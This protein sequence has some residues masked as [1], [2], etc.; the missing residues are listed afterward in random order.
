MLMNGK[1]TTVISRPC[2]TTFIY[3]LREPYEYFFQF[4][5]AEL[6][7]HIVFQS[8]VYSRQKD[9]A[10][11]FH[12]SEEEIL[13]FHGLIVY[14]GL[15]PI[16]SLVNFWAVKTR[17]PQVADFISSNYFK[18]MLSSLHFNDNDQAAVSQVRFFKVRVP[19]TM[20]T[21]E[22]WKVSETPIHSMDEGMVANK[23]KKAGN[24]RRYVAKK[25]DK[26]DYKF[27][28]RSSVDGFV[29]D[30]L[31]YQGETAFMSHHTLLSVE[32]KA[33]SVTSKF[34]FTLVKTIKHPSHLAV[35]ADNYFASI[36]LAGYLRSQ[37]GCWYIG[38]ALKSVKVM[39]KKS[40][41]RSTLDYVYSHGILVAKWKNKSIVTIL[42]TDVGIELMDTVERALKKVPIPCT[43][44]TQMY[45]NRMG[46][47]DKS[48]MLT[49]L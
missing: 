3:Y 25:P 39:N 31:M 15:V 6:R 11:N 19:F 22:F 45:K 14:M 1:R 5:R 30:T 28:C 36:G 23:G 24:L 32:Q 43:S 4:F 26:W 7:E 16:P 12:I 34:A 40:T 41:P 42:S 21:K 37:Y 9:V 44:D 18:S 27:F 8:N 20:V 13:V 2:P 33:M 46:G 10:S 17:I 35:Y 49:H 38:T 47:I 29:H 48:D